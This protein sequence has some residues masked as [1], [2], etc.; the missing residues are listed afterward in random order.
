[1]NK[2]RLSAKQAIPIMQEMLSGDK[3]DNPI[4]VFRVLEPIDYWIDDDR[5]LLRQH[6]LVPSRYGISPAPGQAETTYAV[7][8]WDKID[9]NLQA[10]RGVYVTH[11]TSPDG[12]SYHVLYTTIRED[13]SHYMGFIW[14]NSRTYCQRDV[15]AWIKDGQIVQTSEKEKYAL[16]GAFVSRED[17]LTLKTQPTS[18]QEQQLS[19]PMAVYSY[20]YDTNN[21]VLKSSVLLTADL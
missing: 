15:E 9:Q 8:T 20:A 17:W 13:P 5:A 3:L 7:V 11:K 1:M 12:E 18:L 4:E 21:D 19:C 14:H 6:R 16:H 2:E 10:K